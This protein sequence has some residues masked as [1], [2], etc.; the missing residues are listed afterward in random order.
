MESRTS[1][2]TLPTWLHAGFRQA[3]DGEVSNVSARN[4]VARLV[5]P[6]CP[7]ADD[8]FGAGCAW[9]LYSPFMRREDCF[10]VD[11]NRNRVH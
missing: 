3:G 1:H 5:V 2:P 11:M 9:M 4:W 10:S 8:E 6:M 7:Y